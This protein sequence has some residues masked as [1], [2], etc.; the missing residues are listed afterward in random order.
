MWGDSLN[1]TS[2]TRYM[3]LW[4]EMPGIQVSDLELQMFFFATNEA[5]KFSPGIFQIT[6]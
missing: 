6:G 4:K 2:G 3:F 5:A 1:E